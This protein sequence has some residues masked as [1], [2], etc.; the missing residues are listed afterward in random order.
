MEKLFIVCTLDCSF[1]INYAVSTLGELDE[2]YLE[3]DFVMSNY[4][5]S[6]MPKNLQIQYF[7]KIIS[8]SK[9]GYMIMN[10]GVEGKFCEIDNLSQ[11]DLLKM[12]KGS[13]I[14]KENPLT[15]EKNYLIKW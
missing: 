3:F 7:K 15:Y 11:Q 1:D 8:K 12:I 5:F 13:K 9:N 2:N 4:A 6:E 10:S 14:Y